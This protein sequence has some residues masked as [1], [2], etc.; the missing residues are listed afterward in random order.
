MSVMDARRPDGSEAEPA[1]SVSTGASSTH[2]SS[3]STSLQYAMTPSPGATVAIPSARAMTCVT[4]APWCSMTPEQ[5]PLVTSHTRT[6]ASA[7][8][9]TSV[10]LKSH[11]QNVAHKTPLAW[12]RS[13]CS[14]APSSTRQT[15]TTSSAPHVAKRGVMEWSDVLCVPFAGDRTTGKSES[16]CGSHA[17]IA[18]IASSCAR[19]VETHSGAASSSAAA[20]ARKGTRHVLA[21]PSRPAV[22]ANAAFSSDNASMNLMC[23]Q[24]SACPRSVAIKPPVATHHTLA[25]PSVDA[26]A[27]KV[28]SVSLF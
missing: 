19:R 18:R 26:D 12:P 28:F 1:R 14:K 27:T 23:Q 10:R 24:T 25:S 7:L 4:G 20:A 11:T 9:V 13:V 17:A 15:L 22:T 16:G 8:P 6:V 5:D 3:A 21:S 2:F